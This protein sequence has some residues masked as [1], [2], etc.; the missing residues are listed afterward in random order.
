M[1]SKTLARAYDTLT[2]EE[3]TPLYFAAVARGDKTEVERLSNAALRMPRTWK[4]KYHLV[5]AFA[6]L[7]YIHQLEQLE[8]IAAYF[9]A[10]SQLLADEEDEVECLRK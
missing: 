5:K 7:A 9:F 3:W 6:V 8:S 2:A 4:D 10:K 1:N